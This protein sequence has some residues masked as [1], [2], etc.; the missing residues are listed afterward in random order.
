MISPLVVCGYKTW[1]LTPKWGQHR[2][3][4]F[5][6]TGLKVSEFKRRDVN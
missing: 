6:N 5:E 3:R 4:K 2:L 1:A